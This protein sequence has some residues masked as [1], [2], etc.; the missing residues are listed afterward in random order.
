MSFGNIRFELLT[1]ED[2]PLFTRW[3]QQPHVY[4]FW[5]S[6][7]PDEVAIRSYY[8]ATEQKVF[9]FMVYMNDDP[10]GFIQ[11]QKVVVGHELHAW[12]SSVGETWNIDLLIGDAALTG[13][14]LAQSV[15]EKFI[16]K[17]IREHPQ[18]SLVLIGLYLDNKRAI[19][20]Y[21]KADFYPVTEVRF[22]GKN[23]L[24]MR[25]RV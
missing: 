10:V 23:Y 13:I 11:C 25:R 5:E 6:I 12:A 9:G 7:E 17:L 4:Q 2:I 16:C 14:G 19:R 21:A 3:L 22:R 15:I 24:L 18:I 8:L 1:E 20:A